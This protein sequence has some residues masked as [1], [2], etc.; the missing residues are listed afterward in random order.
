[1][2]KLKKR[3]EVTVERSALEIPN[4]DYVPTAKKELVRKKLSIKPAMLQLNE[5]QD[6]F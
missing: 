6:Y 2:I 3:R 4:K 5:P 1:L